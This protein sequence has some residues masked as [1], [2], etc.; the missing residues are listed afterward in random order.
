[1]FENES[2]SVERLGTDFWRCRFIEGKEGLFS[3]KFLFVMATVRGEAISEPF[4]TL[5]SRGKGWIQV[6]TNKQA[7]DKNQ[8]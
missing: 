5:P 4:P 8:Q 2:A 3:S 1:M 7:K 6:K